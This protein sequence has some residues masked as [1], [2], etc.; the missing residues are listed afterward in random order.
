V[1]LRVALPADPQ[2]AEVVQPGEG[3]L[4]DPAFATQAGA[5]ISAAA[6][7]PMGEPAGAEFSAVL[8]VVIA[9]VGDHSLGP[10]PRP[11]A[12]AGDR[13]DAVD[14]RQ[15]L[16][17]VVA[18]AS[19]QCDRQRHPAG[20]DVEV[21]LGSGAGTVNRRRPGQSPLLKARMWLPSITPVDQSIRPAALSLR[22]SSWCSPR[23]NPW[24]CHSCSR[25]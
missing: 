20:V 11:A 23:Q 10:L 17:D 16:R 22:R 5:V 14:Q 3:A 9:A 21:M 24:R 12:L 8:V 13:R 2:S 18:V 1:D 25:R 19:G 6:G 4:H 7:A 15:Q